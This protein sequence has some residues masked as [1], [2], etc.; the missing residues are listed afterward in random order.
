MC[1]HSVTSH[2]RELDS[3]E[4]CSPIS[5]YLEPFSG[6]MLFLTAHLHGTQAVCLLKLHCRA[7]VGDANKCSMLDPEQGKGL[8]AFSPCLLEIHC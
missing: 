4:L 6:E 5:N 3:L 8:P 1:A 7:D 2:V